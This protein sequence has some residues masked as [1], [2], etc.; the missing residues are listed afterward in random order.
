MKIEK[1]KKSLE[2]GILL[3]PDEIENKEVLIVE[4]F[5]EINAKKTTDIVSNMNLP[6]A[7][8]VEIQQIEIK[9]SL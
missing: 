2:L 9:P 5:N 1:V 3:N 8:K 4:T 7:G 6:I